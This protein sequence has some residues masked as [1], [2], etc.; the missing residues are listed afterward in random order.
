MDQLFKDENKE[1]LALPRG[2]GYWIWKPYYILKTLSMMNDDDVLVYCDMAMNY[3]GSIE[4]YI[5]N[6]KSSIMLFQHAFDSPE[7]AF[8]KGDTF[9]HFN[10]LDNKEITDSTQLDASHSIWK[11]DAKSIAFV[12]EWLNTCKNIQ[13]ISDLP[14]IHPNLDGFAEN[15]HDQS[16][17]SVLAKVKKDEYN[18]QIERSA[19]DYGNGS[20]N[21]DLPQ[22][23]F[24]HR[25]RN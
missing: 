5:N 24:H 11:K 15:R 23:F 10:A 4:P 22:L 21:K 9:K 6:M 7:R 8:T 14:S 1:I 16:I 18:I 20:R 17:L 2:A 25:W 13:L 3:V 19:S 12:T